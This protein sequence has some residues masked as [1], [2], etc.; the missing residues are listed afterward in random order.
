MIKEKSKGDPKTT[1]IRKKNPNNKKENSTSAFL[2][3]LAKKQEVELKYVA[4]KTKSRK[5]LGPQTPRFEIVHQ[6]SYNDYQN[7][8]NAQQKTTR[9]DAILVR[10]YLDL[11]ETAAE[12]ELDLTETTFHLTVPNKYE[13]QTT[14]PFP[15]NKDK[16]SAKFDKSK[17]TL[18]VTLPVVPLPVVALVNVEN[19]RN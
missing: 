17:K 1:V 7:Y 8:S 4:P 14:L 12:V 13:L 16:G 18:S 11:L 10:V 2:D 19:S 5:P 15:V 9:P 6:N 3:D